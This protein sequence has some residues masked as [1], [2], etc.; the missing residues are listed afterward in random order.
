MLKHNWH[1]WTRDIFRCD[2]IWI[3]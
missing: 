1:Y 3:R 2:F